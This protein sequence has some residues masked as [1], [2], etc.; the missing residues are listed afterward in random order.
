MDPNPPEAQAP[1]EEPPSCSLPLLQYGFAHTVGAPPVAV[2]Y[3]PP[4]TCRW[5]RAVLE[6]SASCSGEQ[7]DRIAAVWL[8]GVEILRTSTAKPVGQVGVF[9][10]VRKDVTHFASLLV[11]QMSEVRDRSMA[12]VPSRVLSVMLENSVDDYFKGVYHVNVTLDFYGRGLNAPARKIP[13]LLRLPTSIVSDNP[14]HQ[15]ATISSGMEG[16]GYFN[17]VKPRYGD[18]DEEDPS[19]VLIRQPPPYASEQQKVSNLIG[20]PADLVIPI[21]NRRRGGE[22]GFWF[23]VEKPTDVRGSK[24]RIPRNAYKAVLEVCVSSHGDDEFWYSNPPD[25]YNIQNNIPS[26]RGNWAFRE[27]EVTID[28]LY[29]GSVIPFPVLYPGSINPFFWTPVVAIKAFDMPT[30]DLDLTPFLGNLLNGRPHTVGF[31][32]S[33][34]IPFWLVNANLHLWLDPHL[35]AVPAMLIK[36]HAEPTFISRNANYKFLDGHFQLEAARQARFEGWVRS[37]LGNFTVLIDSH[38]KYKSSVEYKLQGTLK[39]VYSQSK[40][41]ADTRITEQPTNHFLARVI[42]QAKYPV[43][44]LAATASYGDR[45]LAQSNLSHILYEF[46]DVTLNPMRTQVSITDTQVA[47][48]WLQPKGGAL[49]GAALTEQTYQRKDNGNCNTRKLTTKDGGITADLTTIDC[50]VRPGPPI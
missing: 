45:M 5:N 35:P 14:K 32:V 48:G 36:H 2:N 27:V 44:M 24:L 21:A 46:T 30:Y 15:Q 37:S 50:N 38:F 33:Y 7:N 18:E 9:W 34:S 10:K 22:N 20:R 31:K 4:G 47:G 23:R 16:A 25:A 39:E 13:G 8:D 19:A 11:P 43:K 42:N 40:Y 1:A 28:G 17:P 12:P 26:R 49:V 6:F 41:T 3:T 29:A